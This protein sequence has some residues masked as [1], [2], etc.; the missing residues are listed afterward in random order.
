MK[1]HVLVTLVVVSEYLKEM[2]CGLLF[3]LAGL[4]RLKPR[5]LNVAGRVGEYCG[6]GRAV[7]TVRSIVTM[8]VV[9]NF[10]VAEC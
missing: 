4:K 10:I 7:V 5:M 3:P 6:A 1:L 8:A 9:V 2:L